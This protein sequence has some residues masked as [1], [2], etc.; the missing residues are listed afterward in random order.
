MNKRSKQ[1]KNFLRG[2]KLLTRFKLNTQLRT[3][4]FYFGENSPSID[5][6]FVW[7]K[8]PEG[9]MFWSTLNNEF[10]EYITAEDVK[11]TQHYFS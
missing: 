6:A 9:M 7:D 3:Y 11:R 8:T 5:S 10:K 2:K 1:L 4:P